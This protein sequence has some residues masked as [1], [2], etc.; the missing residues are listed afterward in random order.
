MLVLVRKESS[1]AGVTV[2]EDLIKSI[3]NC[4][5]VLMCDPDA[6]VTSYCFLFYL[7]LNIRATGLLIRRQCAGRAGREGGA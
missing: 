5:S 2:S 1:F 3:M 4:L 7:N 6:K